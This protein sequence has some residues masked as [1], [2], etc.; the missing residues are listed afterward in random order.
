MQPHSPAG[1]QPV[2][3]RAHVVAAPG[4]PNSTGSELM[5]MGTGVIALCG[6]MTII[7]V[8]YRHRRTMTLRRHITLLEQA[9]TLSIEE[10]KH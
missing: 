4:Q 7:A 2:V 5:M 8:L 1:P 10:P 3:A 6:L 9:W